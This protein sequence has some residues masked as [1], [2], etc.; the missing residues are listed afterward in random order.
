[1]AAGRVRGREGTSVALSAGVHLFLAIATI[2]CYHEVDPPTAT[3]ATIPRQTATGSAGAEM[4]RYTAT[5]E[6]F[7][8]QLDYLQQN[9][10]HVIALSDLVDYLAGRRKELP[11]RA[12]VITVDDGW[13]CAATTIAP[14]LRKRGMPFTLFIYPEIVGRGSHALTWRQIESLS[15]AGADVESHA[16]T[17]PFLTK[18]QS[19]ERELAGSM[20]EIHRHTG[21]PVRFLSYPYGDFDDAVAGAAAQY[22][23]EAAVTTRRLPVTPETPPMQLGRYLIHNA[24]TLEQFKTFLLP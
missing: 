8:A 9:D 18:S 21:K 10:Y 22:A 20:A 13:A 12:V 19:L 5:P 6:Q 7:T 2:L 11:P 1:V 24:T 15:G 4:R 3:H 16:W 14:E 23:Y 17:H